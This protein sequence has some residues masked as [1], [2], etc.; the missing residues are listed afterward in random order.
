M[1]DN[2]P[3]TGEPSDEKLYRRRML[4]ALPEVAFWRQLSAAVLMSEL[5]I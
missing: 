2:E 4:D 1:L 3:L 5:A